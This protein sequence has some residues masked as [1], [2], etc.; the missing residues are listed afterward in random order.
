MDL[1]RKQLG[2]GKALQDETAAKLSESMHELG[3]TKVL[4]QDLRDNLDKVRHQSEKGFV[5][6]TS[7]LRALAEYSGPM[8]LSPVSVTCSEPVSTAHRPNQ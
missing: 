5:R 7:L 6:N 3:A 2:E 1:L 8:L 4:L